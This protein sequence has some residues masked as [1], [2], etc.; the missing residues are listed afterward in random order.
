MKLSHKAL[1]EAFLAECNRSSNLQLGRAFFQ[2]FEIAHFLNAAY[3]QCINDRIRVFDERFTPS[4]KRLTESVDKSPFPSSMRLLLD[5]GTLYISSGLIKEVKDLRFDGYE[6]GSCGAN[7]RL[8]RVP[9]VVMWVSPTNGEVQGETIDETPYLVN[10]NLHEYHNRTRKATFLCRPIN[11]VDV[12][13]MSLLYQDQKYM[14]YVYYRVRPILATNRNTN[15]D[16]HF[17]YIELSYEYSNGGNTLMVSADMIKWPPML[18]ESDMIKES[19][20]RFI[21]VMFGYEI[22]QR[23]AS[24][25][26]ESLGVNRSQSLARIA[27]ESMPQ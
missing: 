7:T 22:A 13:R 26:M 15:R 12:T 14:P 18:T 1:K 24:L 17:M 21:D 9:Q 5:F 4:D 2:P 23:G 11:P 27:T 16:H 20:S 19:A 25:A 6:V 8:F 3:M 10:V